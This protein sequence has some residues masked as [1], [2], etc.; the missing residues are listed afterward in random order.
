MSRVVIWVLILCMV[1]STRIQAQQRFVSKE[2]GNVFFDTQPVRFTL[3][4]SK[5]KVHVRIITPNEKTFREGDYPERDINLG[6]L[7]WGWYRIVQGAGE[8]TNGTSF[9]VV[10]RPRQKEE[11][12]VA[13]D[14]ALSWLV[15]PE[16]FE[17]VSEMAHR[18]GFVWVRDRL[19]WSEIEPVKGKFLWGKYDKSL[20]IQNSKGLRVVQVFHDTPKWARSDENTHAFPDDLRDAYRS[21]R[22]MAKHFGAV[23]AW[24][25]WNEAD[26]PAFSTEPASEYAAF[27]KAAALGIRSGNGNAQV[28][29]SSIALDS[30]LFTV[31]LAANGT[32]SYFDVFNY[33]TYDTPTNYL[34]HA[35]S[36]KRHREKADALNKPVWLTEAG[37]PILQKSGSLTFAETVEQ[38]KYVVKSYVESRRTGTARHFFFI[39]SPFVENNASF[40]ALDRDLLPLPAYSALAMTANLLGNATYK[41]EIRYR[42]PGL[43]IHVF[44]DGNNDLLVGW[45]DKDDML[46]PLPLTEEARGKLRFVELLNTFGSPLSITADKDKIPTLPLST[47]PILLAVPRGIMADVTAPPSD[48]PKKPEVPQKRVERP[49]IVVRIRPLESKVSKSEEAFKVVK[50]RSIVLEIEVYNFGG[51]L[52]DMTLRLSSESTGVKLIRTTL[53]IERIREMDRFVFKVD[54]SLDA[55]TIRGSVTAQVVGANGERSSPAVVDLIDAEWGR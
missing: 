32:A 52:S 5:N 28:L 1:V 3:S 50:G 2:P 30:P 37:I 11:G 40:G 36:H 53:P 21:A 41:G 12:W 24:E 51:N 49:E 10:P 55:S 9:A 19:S 54:V 34:N 44:D 8:F 6:K 48:A 39:L 31:G 43:H 4:E 46:L 17:A 29:Q 26:I 20:Q 33:H 13:T 45:T 14:V 15:K 23:R 42:Q 7:P 27:F 47:F 22:E 35:N 25:V 38:A 18:A 16:Q